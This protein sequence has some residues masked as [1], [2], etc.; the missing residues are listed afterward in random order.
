MAP[1]RK[2]Y[3]VFL[4]GINVG[5]NKKVPMA[6]L[7]Q[8]LGEMRFTGVKTVLN[9]GNALFDAPAKKPEELAAKIEK[10]FECTFGFTSSAIVRTLDDLR[11]LIATKPFR[12][13]KVTPDT[14]LYVTL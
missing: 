4:R 3:V 5:G 2:T 7:K 13:I 9:S 10:Q 8:L 1:A 11:E 14:R 6:A 12:K